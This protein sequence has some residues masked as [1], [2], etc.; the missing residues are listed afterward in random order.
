MWLYTRWTSLS[1]HRTPATTPWRSGTTFRGPRENCTYNIRDIVIS[2]SVSAAIILYIDNYD[3]DIVTSRDDCYN[4][5]LN[6]QFN[7]CVFIRKKKV[8]TRLI[9]ARHC[10]Q[11]LKRYYKSLYFIS[12]IDCFKKIDLQTKF[13]H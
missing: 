8:L 7:C 10:D 12:H 6:K 4:N 9:T 1:A 11:N 13:Y 2:I 5:L 3:D